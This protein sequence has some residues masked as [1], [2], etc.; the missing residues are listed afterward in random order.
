V[1]RK[2][3]ENVRQTTTSHRSAV[4]EL[5]TDWRIEVV[6]IPATDVDQARAFYIDRVGFAV[7]HDHHVK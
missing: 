7:H 1:G 2:G 3:D 5:I 6:S 4:A